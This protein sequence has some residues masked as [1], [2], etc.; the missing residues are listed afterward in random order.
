MKSRWLSL[1]GLAA[2]VLAFVGLSFMGDTPSL[3]TASS[4]IVEHWTEAANGSLASVFL[5]LAV[6]LLILF[7]SVLLRSRGEAAGMDVWAFLAGTGMA[8]AAV[9]FLIAGGLAAATADAA[10]ASLDD[11]VVSLHAFGMRSHL[12][13]WGGLGLMAIG[14][15]GMAIG[16]PGFRGLFGWFGVVV[17]IVAFTPDPSGMIGAIGSVLFI[18]VTSVLLARSE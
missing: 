13:W 4:E 6:P 9:G 5:V 10:N 17:G 2:V 18:A 11:V 8:I 15:G 16:R 7:G 1:S 3:D 12:V 14:G